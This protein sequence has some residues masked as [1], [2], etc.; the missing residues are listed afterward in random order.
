MWKAKYE[1]NYLGKIEFRTADE[2]KMG[3][4][5]A[6]SGR[7]VETGKTNKAKTA[8]VG[9]ATRLWNRGPTSLTQAETLEGAKREIKKFCNTVPV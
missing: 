5:G 4:R 3:M 1:E 8:F 9:D 2:N 6:T 7:A